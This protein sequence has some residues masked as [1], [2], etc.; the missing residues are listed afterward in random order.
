MASPNSLIVAPSLLAAD[1]SRI[2]TEV[3]AITRAGADWLHLDVMDGHFVPNISFG[4]A[5]VAA[6]LKNCPL[7]GDVHLMIERPDLF[8]DVF[9]STPAHCITVHVEASHDVA[10][11][12]EKIR[13]QGRQAGLA[14][15]PDTP[16]E[17]AL[18]YLAK[19]N[20]LLIMT[21]RPGFGGQKFIVETLP[22]IR[23]AAE[24]RASLC[25]GYRIEVDGGIDVI[26]AKSCTA[27]GADTLV[28]GT[29]VFG[30]HDY[31]VAINALRRCALD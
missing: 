15:N 3:E 4:Q 1:F 11:S 16:I 18:P 28:A 13:A 8:L 29:S 26:T 9:L 20:L 31:A 14:I 2:G 21:V 5:I 30:Q 23:A 24:L 17:K 25:L 27:A 22:K 12:L 7:P 10:A 6:A 19:I